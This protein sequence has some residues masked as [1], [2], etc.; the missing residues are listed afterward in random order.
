MSQAQSGDTV[1]V[2]FTGKLKDGTVIDSS[3]ERDPL[4]LKIGEGRF[5]P[6]FEEAIVGME[7][8]AEKTTEVPAKE[9]FG[10]FR[11]ELVM[12]IPRT[13]FQAGVDLEVGQ[14]FKAQDPQRGSIVVTIVDL[15]EESA[16]IDA[17]HELAGKDLVF[18]IELLEIV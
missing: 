3:R 11:N 13:E 12:E 4:E 10:E 15:S 6:G 1:K 2:H 18:D 9:A 17:N 5:I 14:K 7:P 8:G 16:T